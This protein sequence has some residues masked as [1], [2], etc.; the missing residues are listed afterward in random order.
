MSDQ[1]LRLFDRDYPATCG[2]VQIQIGD[3]E[4]ES[5]CREVSVVQD[6]WPLKGSVQVSSLTQ[7]CNLS[8]GWRHRGWSWFES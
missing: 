5:D 7:I 2:R 8:T 6:E 1:Q 3:Y 4:A